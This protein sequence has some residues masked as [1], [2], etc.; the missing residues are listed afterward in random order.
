VIP[1]TVVGRSAG[2]LAIRREIAALG[3]AQPIHR[4]AMRGFGIELE[5]QWAQVVVHGS[6]QMSGVDAGV[7][8]EAYRATS[9]QASN[10]SRSARSI[11]ACFG[12]PSFGT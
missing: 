5:Q 6:G 3:H 8:V 1:K 12:W 9:A 2:G 10:S 4:H 11:G 7:V